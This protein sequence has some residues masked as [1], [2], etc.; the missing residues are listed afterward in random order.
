MPEIVQVTA[1]SARRAQKMKVL[2]EAKEAVVQPMH[3]YELSAIFITT[4]E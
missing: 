1:D 2:H 4:R 3:K